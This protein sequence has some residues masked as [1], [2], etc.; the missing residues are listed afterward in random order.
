MQPSPLRATA[1]LMILIFCQSFDLPFDQ[2]R[3]PLF[4]T[5]V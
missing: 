1:S 2:S 3:F 5:Y 4:G